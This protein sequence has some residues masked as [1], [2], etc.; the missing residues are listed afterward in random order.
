[1]KLCRP[2]ARWIPARVLS[3]NR[4]GTFHLDCKSDVP[5]DRIRPA[6]KKAPEHQA[7]SFSP[8]SCHD[9]PKFSLKTIKSQ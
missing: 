5:Q 1:M 9:W 3:A 2:I 8:C 4:D 7:G 6:V